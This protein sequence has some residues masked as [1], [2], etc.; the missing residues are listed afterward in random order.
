MAEHHDV[1]VIGAGISG[2]DA[3]YHLRYLFGWNCVTGVQ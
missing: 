1:I 3:A 2:I